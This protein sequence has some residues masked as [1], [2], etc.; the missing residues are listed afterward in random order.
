MADT[1]DPASSPALTLRQAKDALLPEAQRL[2][3]FLATE[4]IEREAPAISRDDVGKVNPVI[5]AL[6]SPSPAAF[7]KAA[8]DWAQYKE[9]G[10]E[11]VPVIASTGRGRGYKNVVVMT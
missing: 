11:N 4:S 10:F 6:G 7:K 2:L 3:E 8:L 9:W 1:S 5:L